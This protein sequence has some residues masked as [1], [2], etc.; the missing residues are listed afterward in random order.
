MVSSREKPWYEC[1]T[2]ESIK[3][4]PDARYYTNGRNDISAIL[5]EIMGLKYRHTS[6]HNG[7]LPRN[8]SALLPYHGKFGT[9]YIYVTYHSPFRVLYKYF[10]M[11]G[12]VE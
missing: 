9:G 3:Q 1:T 5:V 11:E 8:D 2:K 7:Y 10:I 6:T 4:D 12:G